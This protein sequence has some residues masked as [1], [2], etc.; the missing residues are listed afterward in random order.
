VTSLAPTE[1]AAR[2]RN[3]TILAATPQRFGAV[4]MRTTISVV[5]FSMVFLSIARSQHP[6]EPSVY[7]VDDAYDVY[8][9]LLPH[10][11]SFEFAKSTLV[12][13]QETASKPD[14]VSE[15]CVTADAALR[16]KDAIA[17][18]NRVNRRQWLLQRRFHID[19]PYQIVSS[20]TISHLFKEG[21]WDA[22]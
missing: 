11:E 3:V 12:I 17:D 9:V 8:S 19:K 7:E 2:S 16:F 10:E 1:Y 6:T 21:S 20:D 13:R 5:I 22:F 14:N 4:E 18:Y 15:P